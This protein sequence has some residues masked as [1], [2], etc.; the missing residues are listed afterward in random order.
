MTERR[1]ITLFL[2]LPSRGTKEG[3]GKTSP[4]HPLTYEDIHSFQ[5]RR[6]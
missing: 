4:Y 5:R 3:K 2:K 1:V 6:R